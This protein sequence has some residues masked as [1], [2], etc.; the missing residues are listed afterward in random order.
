MKLSIVVPCYNEKA[1]VPLLI[2]RFAQAIRRDDVEVV[3]V[4]NGSTDG[5]GEIFEALLPQ[6][7][8]ARYVHVP[9]NRGYGHGILQGLHNA[10]GEFLGW[11]HADLQTDPHDV[12]KALA[13]VEEVKGNDSIYVKGCRRGRP[14]FDN[15][16]TW[17]MSFF[18]SCLLGKWMWDINAQPNI[19]HKSF[20]Q[21]WEHP[22]DDFSLDL[23]AYYMALKQKCT[24]VRFDVSFPKRVHGMSH[25]NTGI[26]A[27][28]K[29]IKR[30][31]QFSLTLKR[32]L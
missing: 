3:F 32:N 4:N 16:F 7:R 8:F 5:S 26:T 25:W 17:G 30:T 12:L 27:K 2:E 18:E 19:F 31:F 9:I 21:R 11:T 6:H 20:F 1:N 29:F 22:P 15:I 24:I 23:F 13:L 10:T 14:V 28:W